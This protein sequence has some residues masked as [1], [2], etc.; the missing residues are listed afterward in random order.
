MDSW[1]TPLPFPERFD[2]Q[3]TFDATPWLTAPFAWDHLEETL[4]WGNI[5]RS[6]A[7]VLDEGCELVAGRL[8]HFV[9]DPLPDVGQ[10]VGAHAAAASSRV[11]G[12]HDP[13]RGRARV[14]FM[15]STGVVAAFTSFDGRGYLR[16]SAHAYTTIDDFERLASVG[17]P[18]L[19]RWSEPSRERSEGLNP[20]EPKEEQCKESS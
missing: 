19:H 18:Q 7:E 13:G 2:M 6:S 16:L 12:D 17:I 14:R 4:G 8:R 11:T 20:K 10:P 1:G 5:R 15:D 9:E 3:G